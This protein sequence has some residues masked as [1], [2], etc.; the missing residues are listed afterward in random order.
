ME[1]EQSRFVYR[2]QAGHPASLCKPV[3]IDVDQCKLI[4]EPPFK[5]DKPLMQRLP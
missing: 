2:K 5:R 3:D 4:T 1:G